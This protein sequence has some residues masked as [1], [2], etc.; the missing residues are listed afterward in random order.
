M[1][2]RMEDAA[3]RSSMNLINARI[4]NPRPTNPEDEQNSC[5]SAK[6]D[7]PRK[8]DRIDNTASIRCSVVFGGMNELPSEALADKRPDL[9]LAP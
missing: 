3:K 5:G 4:P 7:Y 1:L 9:R 2:N 6:S 8:C